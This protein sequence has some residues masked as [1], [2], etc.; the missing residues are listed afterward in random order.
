VRQLVIK[1]LNELRTGRAG[2]VD[3][4]QVG[5]TSVGTDSANTHRK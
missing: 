1:V 3:T 2:Y 4:F 5:T